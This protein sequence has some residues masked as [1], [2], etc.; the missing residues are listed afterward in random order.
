MPR[1]FKIVEYSRAAEAISSIDVIRH[2]VDICYVQTQDY[3]LCLNYP[4]LI[5]IDPSTNPVTHF[6]YAVTTSGSA[7]AVT[8]TRNALDG[9]TVGDSIVFDYDV[10]T[11]VGTG[12]FLGMK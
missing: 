2:A 4:D 7:Y 8:A 3:S 9:G 10:N 1:Y 12:A 5:I 6:T 11:R